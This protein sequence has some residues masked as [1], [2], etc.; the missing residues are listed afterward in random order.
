MN[1]VQKGNA[2]EDRVYVVLKDLIE[3]KQFAIDKNNYRIFQK[4]GYPSKDQES[5]IIFDIAIEVFMPNADKFSFLYLIE[6]KD[7]SSPISVDKVRN[8]IGQVREVGGHKAFFFTTSKFQPGAINIAK[9]NNMGLVIINESNNVN[10]VVRRSVHNNRFTLSKSEEYFSGKCVVDT[11]FIGYDYP[12]VYG[13]I[14]DFLL[15][16]NIEVTHKGLSIDFISDDSIA[17]KALDVA[18]IKKDDLTYNMTSFAMIDIINEE[19]IETVLDAELLGG[20]L[21]KYDV[22][23]RRLFI[24]SSLSFDT[25]RWRFTLA[26]ELGH[27][28][29]HREILESYKVEE[30]YDDE[31][32]LRFK[33]VSNFIMDKELERMEIQANK[34]A[35]LFLMPSIPLACQ[36]ELWKKKTGFP[37]KYLFLDSNEWNIA[38]C[39]PAFIDLSAIFGVSKEAMKYRLI[40][41]GFC[42]ES[43]SSGKIGSLLR[44]M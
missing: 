28:V 18:G 6:C 34:F 24:S 25:P 44:R 38:D 32:V 30:L 14:I 3:R 36:F 21:A 15:A 8:F 41:M 2:F 40:G 20:E 5:D 26:H 23:N 11:P 22:L 27:I 13:H 43:G 10:W 9:T 17:L 29:L 19:G 31:D 33:S 1:T 16:N 35:S 42:K 37:Y 12:Y 7:Y 4:K 39:E